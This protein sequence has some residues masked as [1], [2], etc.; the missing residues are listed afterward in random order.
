MNRSESDVIVENI[1]EHHGV[2][3][4]RWGFRKGP[5]GS[6]GFGRKNPKLPPS[7]DAQNAATLKSHVKTSGVQSLSNTE[8]QALVSR[9]NL[10][11]QFAKLSARPSRV[12]KGQKKIKTILSLGAT[13]ND[14]HAYSKTPTGKALTTQLSK[15]AKKLAKV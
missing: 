10:E 14:I 6:Y 2:L 3:G 1:L 9:M 12:D 13:A 15:H 7:E 8:L 4:M 5:D 11:S